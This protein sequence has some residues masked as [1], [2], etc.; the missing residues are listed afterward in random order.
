M[1]GAQAGGGEEQLG[2]WA[3]GGQWVVGCEGWCCQ[4]ADTTTKTSCGK[5][6]KKKQERSRRRGLGPQPDVSG[7]G[8]AARVLAAER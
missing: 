6:P 1:A 2:Q 5:E 3:G 4:C 7:V 8:P